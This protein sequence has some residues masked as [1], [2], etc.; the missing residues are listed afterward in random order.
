MSTEVAGT[1][2]TLGERKLTTLHAIGQSL[3]LGPMFSVGIVLGSVSRARGGTPRS[4][5]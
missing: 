4:A 1:P 5:S 2:D 3:A